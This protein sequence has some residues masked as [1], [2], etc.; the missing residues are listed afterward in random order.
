[1]FIDLKVLHV[2]S[3]N[4]KLTTWVVNVAHASLGCQYNLLYLG[5][6]HLQ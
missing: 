6:S 2:L 1:M 4:D 5:G 3:R